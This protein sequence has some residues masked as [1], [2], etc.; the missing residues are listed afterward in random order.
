MSA[1]DMASDDRAKALEAAIALGW[2]DDGDTKKGYTR[3]KCPCGKHMT[4]LHKTPSNPNYWKEAV[5]HL[6]VKCPPTTD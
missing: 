1:R 6:K 4:W 3:L 5:G 2:T